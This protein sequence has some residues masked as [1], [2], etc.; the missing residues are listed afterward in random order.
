MVTLKSGIILDQ[1][2]DG[3]LKWAND[4]YPIQI[5]ANYSILMGLFKFLWALIP[6]NIFCQNTAWNDSRLLDAQ[7]DINE[8]VHLKSFIR[9]S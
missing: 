5:Y 8:N 9:D 7:C 3:L 6:G 1:N 2:D 4:S